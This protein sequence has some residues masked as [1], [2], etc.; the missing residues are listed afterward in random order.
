M[1]TSTNTLESW[2]GFAQAESTGSGCLVAVNKPDRETKPQGRCAQTLASQDG[3]GRQEWAK[4]DTTSG[5]F[6]AK[7]TK[8]FKSV[9]REKASRL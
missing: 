5:A 7:E 9:R 8:K 6:M 1:T 3:D 4:R 2:K